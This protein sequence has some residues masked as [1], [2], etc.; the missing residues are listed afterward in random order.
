ME[1]RFTP[2]LQAKLDRLV[3]ET[4]RP[5]DE[6]VQDAMAG[7]FDELADIRAT[8]NSRYDGLKSGRAKPVSGDEVIARL[9]ARNAARRAGH[10]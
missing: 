4:G 2:D 8:L 5:A 1:V 7:Y 3:T 9:R 10:S 6:F